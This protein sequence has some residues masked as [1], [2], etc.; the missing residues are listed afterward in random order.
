MKY[1]ALLGMLIFA[2]SFWR[3]EQCLRLQEVS[4]LSDSTS[5]VLCHLPVFG[6]LLFFLDLKHGGPPLGPHGMGPGCR[7][8]FSDDLLVGSVEFQIL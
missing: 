5:L 4:K 7:L 1:K 2:V 8:E 6:L 3:F